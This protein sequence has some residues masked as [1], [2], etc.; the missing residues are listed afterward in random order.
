M[1]LIPLKD[2]AAEHNISYEAVRSQVA[3]YRDQLGDHV[4]KDGRQQFL[5]A[6]AVAFLDERRAKNP[7]VIIQEGKDDQIR[8]L[9]E[10]NEAL[11]RKIAAQADRIS[12]L[13]QWKA[14]HALALASADQ[15]QRLLEDTQAKLAERDSEV[16][17]ALQKA[18]EGEKRAQEAEELAAAEKAAREATEA[19]NARLQEDMRALKGRGLIA[20]ILRRG[21]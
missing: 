10:E 16:A 17:E 5:D 7:V 9:R 14:D 11:L 4:I 3:R 1:N 21:E 18:Q 2:Y 19:D 13:A 12:E 20:R 8:Q 15:T 6:F